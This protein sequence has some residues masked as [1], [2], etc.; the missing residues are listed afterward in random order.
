LY[1]LFENS[2]IRRFSSQVILSVDALFGASCSQEIPTE[3][4][5]QNAILLTGTLLRQG[6]HDIYVFAE[7]SPTTFDLDDAVLATARIDQA[8]F[9]AGSTGGAAT[10][11]QHYRFAFRGGLAFRAPPAGTP[12]LFSF[13]ELAYVNLGVV[14]TFDLS[15]GKPPHFDFDP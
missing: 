9:S 1:V 15:S 8:T 10:G 13:D 4:L 6:G 5:P 7:S 14:M 11:P 12:D 2:T 3:G